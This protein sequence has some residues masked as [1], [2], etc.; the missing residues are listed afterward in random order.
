M[1]ALDKWRSPG[2]VLAAPLPGI[3][4]DQEHPLS[5]QMVPGLNPRSA[6]NWLCALGQSI[7]TSLNVLLYTMGKLGGPASVS[8]YEESGRRHTQQAKLSVLHRRGAL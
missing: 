6:S 5:R 7:T 3:L 2:R 4:N 8:G 1:L